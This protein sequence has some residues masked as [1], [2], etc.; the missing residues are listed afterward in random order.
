MGISSEYVTTAVLASL[1]ASGQ[2]TPEQQAALAQAI[3][4]GIEADHDNLRRSVQSLKKESQADQ[5][6]SL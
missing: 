2:F 5:A 3:V 4:A 1:E 6:S